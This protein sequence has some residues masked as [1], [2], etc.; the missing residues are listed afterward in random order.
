MAVAVILPKLDE[1][2]TSGKIAKWLKKEGDSVKKGESIFEVETEKVNFEVEAEASG[3]LSKIM[4]E[5]GDDVDVGTTIAFIL[6]P[7]EK[8]SDVP[9]PA[10]K[11]RIQVEAPTVRTEAKA[12]KASP[13]AKR[14]A[15][16][17]NVDLSL[18]AGTGPRGRI[19]KEDILQAIGKRYEGGHW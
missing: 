13:L 15:K 2:M 4:A 11:E 3:I 7:G 8:P 18:V 10:V 12:I 5:V 6:Q 14:I 19:S 9:E 1:A 16:E 17:N